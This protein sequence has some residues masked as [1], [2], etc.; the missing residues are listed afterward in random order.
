MI[1]AF[2]RKSEKKTTEVVLAV[3]QLCEDVGV[4]QYTYT[5][6]AQ[7]ISLDGYSDINTHTQVWLLCERQ[8]R[9]LIAIAWTTEWTDHRLTK[10]TYTVSTKNTAPKHVSK[11]SKLASFVH[12]QL[13]SMNICLFSIKSSILVKICP[14]VIEILTFNKWSEK[15]T[16]S[17]S[18]NCRQHRRSCRIGKIKTN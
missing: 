17:R 7:L 13:N 10:S 8:R 2:G 9:L 18:V 6:T 5:P 12:L 16:V 3:A 14:T 1:R 11:S 15:V 4:L